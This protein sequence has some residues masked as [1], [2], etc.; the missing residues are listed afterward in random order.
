MTIEE[1]QALAARLVAAIAPDI[2]PDTV[3]TTARLREDLDLDSLD[4]LNV[5]EAVQQETGVS[6]PESDYPKIT[7]IAS[8]A[9][10]LEQHAAV[11]S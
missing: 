6:I 1:S 4:F 8:L 7:S 5:V 3:D 11:G 9:S 10:Y 2:D